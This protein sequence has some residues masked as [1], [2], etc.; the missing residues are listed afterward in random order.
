[1]RIFLWHVLTSVFVIFEDVPDALDSLFDDN[2]KSSTKTFVLSL[3]VTCWLVILSI[4]SYSIF[5]FM[6]R[7]TFFIVSADVEQVSI[8]PYDDQANPN[9]KFNNAVL[10]EDCGE[11]SIN[12]SGTLYPHATVYIDFLRI[13]Q[14]DLIINLDNEDNDSVGIFIEESGRK[15]ILDDCATIQ[16][17]INDSESFVFPVQGKIKLGGNIKDDSNITPLLYN[18]EISIVDKTLLTRT[19]YS[20]GP[21]DLNMGDIFSVEDA[22]VK[23]SGF[24]QVDDE[25]GIKVTYSSKGRKAYIKKY[26]TENITIENGFWTKIYNDQSLIV[27]WFLGVFLFALC[28][29]RIRISLAKIKIVCGKPQA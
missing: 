7:P 1:M 10:Y 18:G 2:K 11:K 20:I 14:K 4:A 28:K 29:A 8:S 26:R 16:V 22:I 5:Y 23:S 12:V 3:V 24:V 17:S 21:F 27:L 9:L 19:Y 6:S 25:K 13:Q 15:I